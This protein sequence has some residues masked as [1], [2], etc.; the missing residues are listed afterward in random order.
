MSHEPPDREAETFRRL[1]EHMKAEAHRQESP[2]ELRTLLSSVGETNRRAGFLGWDPAMRARRP[3]GDPGRAYPRLH[4]VTA[5]HPRLFI[6]YSWSQDMNLKTGEPDHWADAF[7]GFLFGRGYDLVYDRDPR[8]VD[9]GLSWYDLLFRM[10]DCNY[11][12][13]II[14]ER[15]LSRFGSSEVGAAAAEWKHAVQGYPDWFTFIGI[16]RSGTD[17]PHPFDAANLVDVRSDENRAPW[18]AP[19][20]RMFPAAPQGEWGRPLLPPPHRPPDP[21]QWPAYVP[22]SD[23]QP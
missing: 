19:I 21:P 11:F 5:D 2:E 3:L 20:S 9:K 15:L 1:H 16:W 14:T 13:F 17:L 10:N 8:N 22:Y 6:S 12:V 23:G 4:P 18:S 7:A